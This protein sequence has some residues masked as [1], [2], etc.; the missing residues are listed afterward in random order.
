[1]SETPSSPLFDN[2]RTQQGVDPTAPHVPE[3]ASGVRGTDQEMDPAG[4]GTGGVPSG[5]DGETAA[6]ERLRKDLGERP[7]DAGT[8][9]GDDLEQ[10]A[11]LGATDD[12]QGGSIQR[13]GSAPGQPPYPPGQP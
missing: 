8:E 10:E 9:T 7:Q 3:P 2:T 12:P 4:P 1:M 6:R 13:D 5:A 11:A